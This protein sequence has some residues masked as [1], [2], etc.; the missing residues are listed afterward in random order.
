ML[1]GRRE[2]SVSPWLTQEWFLEWRCVFVCYSIFCQ[3]LLTWKSPADTRC[4][5][6]RRILST[7]PPPLICIHRHFS[8]RL[9]SV[10]WRLSDKWISRLSRCQPASPSL[11]RCF[12]LLSAEIMEHPRRAESKQGSSSVFG[13]LYVHNY[14][15][16]KY[17][18]RS[19]RRSTRQR[20]FHSFCLVSLLPRV[21]QSLSFMCEG[22]NEALPFHPEFSWLIAPHGAPPHHFNFKWSLP[23]PPVLASKCS[24]AEMHVPVGNECR[25][26]HITTPFVRGDA[27]LHR[28]NAALTTRRKS[29]RDEQQVWDVL[30]SFKSSLANFEQRDTLVCLNEVRH[31]LP[32]GNSTVDNQAPAIVY[33][34]SVLSPGRTQTPTETEK[35]LSV[36]KL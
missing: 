32:S 36:L 12:H 3:S 13:C 4:R 2:E 15:A 17:F 18:D 25:H 34:D 21:P 14:S 23:T 8:L 9:T 7:A 31:V 27:S 16:A 11:Y 24:L 30:L 22:I 33:R 20:P 26:L 6:C 28:R 29:R 19:R 1:D 10:F 5:R 35:K